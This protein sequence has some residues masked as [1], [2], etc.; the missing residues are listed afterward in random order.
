MKC[1]SNKCNILPFLLTFICLASTALSITLNYP[2][3]PF[4]SDDV[5]LSI[6]GL[7]NNDLLAEHNES[8]LNSP[9]HILTLLAIK[10]IVQLVGIHWFQTLLITAA[11]S[12]NV[13][14]MLLGLTV[15][16]ATN[17]IFFSVVSTILFIT[18]AWSQTYL[19]FYTYAPVAGL[20]MMASL[21]CFIRYYFHEP[22][23]GPLPT[24]TG[25]FLGLFFLS[26]SSAKLLAFIL[27]MSY[28]IVIFKFSSPKKSNHWLYFL[29]AFAIPVLA[30]LPIYIEPLLIHLKTNI[31]A[32]NAALCFKKYGLYPTT[33]F[34]SFFYLL[35]I[36]SP[37]MCLFSVASLI[38]SIH[39]W[40]WFKNIGNQGNLLIILVTILLFHVII[41]DILPYTKHGRAQFPL[42]PILLMTLA[43]IYAN[44]P[45]GKKI[46]TWIFIAFML[47]SVPL[48]I[49]ATVQTWKVR[50]TAPSALQ[51]LPDG[52]RI[53]FVEE[54]PHYQFVELWLGF[55]NIYIIKRSELPYI[56]KN[57]TTPIALI[58]GPTGLNSGKSILSCCILDDF[59]FTLPK[60]IGIH[61]SSVLTIP[62][63][64]YYPFFM[65]EEE[66]SQYFFF[67]HMVPDSKAI[68]SHLKVY[69]W[70]LDPRQNM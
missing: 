7:T 50:K 49:A 57:R 9:V 34:F 19:H 62:Y 46:G 47:I 20:F 10:H 37:V 5:L 48:E 30:F 36:Y 23:R 41:L 66:N 70:Q 16:I 32:G 44:F 11:F 21:Y 55:D 18:S 58:I 52:T 33:P 4:P 54:D 12:L 42:M 24:L 3:K 68:Q 43:I 56:I 64:S 26:S 39:Q 29:L 35:G 6:N 63:Y 69:F 28:L 45:A 67:N 38:I 31:Y 27:F 25:F 13:T 17:R 8:I 40:K 51:A 2:Y 61:T 65:M 60:E 22:E 14:A 15:H 59:Y 53:Y 1:L